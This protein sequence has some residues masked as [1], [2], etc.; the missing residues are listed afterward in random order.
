MRIANVFFD[1]SGYRNFTV[2]QHI[3]RALRRARPSPVV[4][5][6]A[7]ILHQADLPAL[8]AAR[9]RT[10]VRPHLFEPEQWIPY[11]RGWLINIVGCTRC[12]T[13][14]TKYASVTTMPS[15]RTPRLS[16]WRMD[17]GQ[18]QTAARRLLPP[19]A[20]RLSNMV[21]QL[22]RDLPELLAFFRFPRHLWR[23][24]R[25]TNIIER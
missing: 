5:R 2:S 19:L 22:E 9:S 6:N 18:A 3:C 16:I 8:T 11:I 24:L 12:A 4:E 25:T 14:W 1:P 23:K 7:H 20:P 10:Y 15:R 13:V 21:R 17:I